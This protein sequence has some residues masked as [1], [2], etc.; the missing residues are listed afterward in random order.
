MIY[1]Y[2]ETDKFTPGK[3]KLAT[4]LANTSHAETDLEA[5]AYFCCFIFN[6]F[7]QLHVWPES[8]LSMAFGVAKAK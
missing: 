3:A 4:I 6:I 8:D 2:W 5:V 7:F 1:L